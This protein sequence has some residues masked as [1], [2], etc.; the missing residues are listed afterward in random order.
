MNSKKY[1]LYTTSIYYI[2]H[3]I[4]Y[5]YIAL[6]GRA[7]QDLYVEYSTIIFFIPATIIIFVLMFKYYMEKINKNYIFTNSEI[8]AL[9]F[10]LSI[11][12]KILLFA[13]SGLV[14]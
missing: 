6:F 5:A 1:L 12:S 4:M 9:I 10:F 3:W 14:E 13:L 7:Y 2:A 11:F 8:I